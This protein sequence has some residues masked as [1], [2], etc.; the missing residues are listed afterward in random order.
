M[1]YRTTFNWGGLTDSEVSP[2]ASRQEAPQNPGIH[3]AGGAKSSISYS[4]RNWKTV[5]QQ[6]REGSLSSP[7][8]TPSDTLSPKRSYL[9][10]QGHTSQ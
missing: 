4:K 6:P 1:L 3:G 9:V 7:T 8:H 5:F 2:L 10:Q